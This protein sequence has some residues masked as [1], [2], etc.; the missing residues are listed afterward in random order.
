MNLLLSSHEEIVWAAGFF[1]GEG[2]ARVRTDPRS[3]RFSGP[4]V[5]IGQVNVEPLKRFVD[6]FGI[7]RIWLEERVPAT[8]KSIWRWEVASKRDVPKLGV[9]LPYLSTA[10]RAQLQAAIDSCVYVRRGSALAER[11]AAA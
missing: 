4:H 8:H 6:I 5:S 9:L 11:R 1:E 3:P 2:C 10:K 7:G